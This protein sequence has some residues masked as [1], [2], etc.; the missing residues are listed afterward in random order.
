MVFFLRVVLATLIVASV[1]EISGRWPRIGALLLSLPLT[2]ILAFG[3]SWQAHG[4]LKSM[5]AMAR[6]TLILVPLTLPFFVPLAFAEQWHLS[7]WTAIALGGG[8]S[9]AVILGWIFFSQNPR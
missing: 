3:F 1:S 6:E 5:S 7:F 2:S 8:I 9:S 4:D